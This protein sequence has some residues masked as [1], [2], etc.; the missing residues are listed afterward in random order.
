MSFDSKNRRISSYKASS[1]YGMIEWALWPLFIYIFPISEE[2][3]KEGGPSMNRYGFLEFMPAIRRS[4]A[5]HR[6][7]WR[8][9]F[10][11]SNYYSN[12]NYFTQRYVPPA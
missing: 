12:G 10:L 11:T 3:M 1:Y 4:A 6:S 5:L 9:F 2:R 7:S 8:I